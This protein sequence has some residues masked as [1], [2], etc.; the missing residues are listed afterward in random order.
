[1]QLAGEYQTAARMEKKLAAVPLPELRGKRV[2]DVG[3]DHGAWC[4]LALER[5]AREVVGVDRGREVR[6]A[7]FVNLAERNKAAIPGCAFL[8]Y[9]L[10]RQY[11]AIGEF[12]VVLMLN[13]YHH[14]FNVAGEHE[15]IWFWLWSQTAGN[16]ELLWENPVDVSDGV[17]NQNIARSLHSAYNER[18]IRAAAERYFD[19]EVVGAGWTPSRVVWRCRP[20]NSY[21]GAP[22]IAVPRDG[23][24]GASKAFAYADGRRAK[25]IETILGFKPTPG[26][27]NLT[28]DRPFDW[29]SRY[30]RAQILDVV[31]RKAGLASEWAPRWC[32]FYP[33]RL[34]DHRAYALRFENE[35]YSSGKPYPE[36]FV[37]LIAPYRLRENLFLE[38]G[39]EVCLTH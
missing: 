17:A 4:S 31:N 6:G 26:S 11:P 5:G 24:G 34:L 15:P 30:Y 22:Y 1:M 10:G 3:C 27:L 12:D 33:V 7:G 32:R 13:L 35:H 18:A 14:V 37:E 20:K 39:S 19:I 38:N 29:N 16:G 2:L 8:D 36:T 23:A 28:V 9:E 21:P 25:E